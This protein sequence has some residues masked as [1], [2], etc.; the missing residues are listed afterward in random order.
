MILGNTK[1]AHTARHFA[2]YESKITKLKTHIERLREAVFT[3]KVCGISNVVE[4]LKRLYKIIDE[5][6][7]QSLAKHDDKV[8]EEFVDWCD[9]NID[10]VATIA[11]ATELLPLFEKDRINRK[12]NDKG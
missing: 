9:K 3:V 1:E 10:I 7:E 2:A 8:R 5:I 11:T 12:N 6:P 4:N